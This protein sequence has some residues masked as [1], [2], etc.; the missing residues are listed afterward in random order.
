[1]N[2][3]D[4]TIRN[5]LEAESLCLLIVSSNRSLSASTCGKMVIYQ[6]ISAYMCVNDPY[7]KFRACPAACSIADRRS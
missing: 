3:F 4:A 7:S 1:M 6:N 2:G 5:E